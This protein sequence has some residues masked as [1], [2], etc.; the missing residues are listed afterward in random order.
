MITTA[1]ASALRSPTPPIT[2]IEMYPAFCG[3]M[4]VLGCLLPTALLEVASLRLSANISLGC[5][6]LNSDAGSC[7]GEGNAAP[8]G[9]DATPIVAEPA[10]ARAP[11]LMAAVDKG[12]S[13]AEEPLPMICSAL[14]M[15]GTYTRGP[16]SPPPESPTICAAG[17]TGVNTELKQVTGKTRMIV[18]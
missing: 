18:Q 15:V 17:F 6:R 8:A 13:E 3:V 4:P 7:T 1:A 2:P 9:A 5:V 12:K 10:G 11:G 16:S 14:C